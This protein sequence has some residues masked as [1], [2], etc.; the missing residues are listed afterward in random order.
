[1]DEETKAKSTKTKAP[2]SK[3]KHSPEETKRRKERAIERRL[4]RAGMRERYFNRRRMAG[5]PTS[6]EKRK[7]YRAR[8]F[9]KR[10]DAPLAPSTGTLS[11]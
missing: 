6:K 8:L 5:K 11:Q 10:G 9:T 1:M 3:G 2:S 7:A 4:H